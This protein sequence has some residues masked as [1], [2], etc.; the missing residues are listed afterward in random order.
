MFLCQVLL[1]GLFPKLYVIEYAITIACIQYWIVFYCPAGTFFVETENGPGASSPRFY[2]VFYFAVF[3]K[4]NF[5]FAFNIY[6]DLWVCFFSIADRFFGL[7]VNFIGNRSVTCKI[8]K[9]Q[10][11]LFFKH[12]YWNLNSFFVFKNKPAIKQNR[13]IGKSSRHIAIIFIE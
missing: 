10:P 9:Q 1:C 6:L 4:V 11:R 3:P 2:L 7:I 13:S 12:N 8:S 5:V